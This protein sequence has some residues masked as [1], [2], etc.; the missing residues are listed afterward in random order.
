[1]TYTQQGM[2]WHKVRQSGGRPA[3][4]ADTRLGSSAAARGREGQRQ[5]RVVEKPTE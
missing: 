4:A 3:P 2:P 1:M 5:G